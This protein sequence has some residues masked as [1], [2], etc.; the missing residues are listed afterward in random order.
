MY[1]LFN[2]YAY[3]LANIYL[4]SSC[5]FTVRYFYILNAWKFNFVIVTAKYS[6]DFS[7]RLAA[8]MCVCAFECV[9]LSVCVCC[10]LSAAVS[11]MCQL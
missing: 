4:F 9:C 8:R 1:Q 11:A 2:L 5:K 6:D 7:F 10:A 3:A